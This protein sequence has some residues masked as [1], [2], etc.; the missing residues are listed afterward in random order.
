MSYSTIPASLMATSTI[1]ETTAMPKEANDFGFEQRTACPV[2]GCRQTKV[3][4]SA[5]FTAPPI[6][7]YLEEFYSRQGKIEFEYLENRDYILDEC[8]SCSLIF[9]RL[10]PNDALMMKLYE[11]WIDPEKSYSLRLQRQDAQYYAY[12]A[13]SIQT[14][15]EYLGK[16]PVDLEFLDFGMGWGHWCLMAQAFGCAVV[17]AELSPA[18]IDHAMELGIEVIAW[19]NLPQRQFDLIHAEQVLEHLP[20]PLGTIRYLATA[21]KPHGLIELVVP[22]AWNAKQKLA[23]GDWSAPSGSRNSLVTVAPLEHINCFTERSLLKLARLASL[24]PVNVRGQI[25]TNRYTT[26]ADL[27]RPAYHWFIKELLGQQIGSVRLFLRRSRLG[28]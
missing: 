27:L 24:E 22:N 16:L 18:R 8:Q 20:D 15:V 13:N 17:G 1:S 21:L 7:T 23:T 28:A 4:Y 26:V 14:V 10:V 5:P 25:K 3:V 19:D 9:Q 12:L 6:S 2:C 11:E